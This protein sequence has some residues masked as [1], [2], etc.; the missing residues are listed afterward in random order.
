MS[1]ATAL[2]AIALLSPALAAPLAAAGNQEFYLISYALSGRELS[3]RLGTF[4]TAF[5]VIGSVTSDGELIAPQQ[6]RD[7]WSQG[8]ELDLTFDLA[9]DA[10]TATLV[11]DSGRAANA[12]EESF[13]LHLADA[14]SAP[15]VL[16]LDAWS[17]GATNA[18]VLLQDAR[19]DPTG[20]L[21]VSIEDAGGATIGTPPELAL[22]GLAGR[23]SQW[24]TFGL[25]LPASSARVVVSGDNWSET[26]PLHLRLPS[27]GIGNVTRGAG[28][29]LA[30]EID[31]PSG[32]PAAN[33]TV[34]VE[35]TSGVTIAS[36]LAR[37]FDLAAASA[38]SAD[39]QLTRDVNDARIVLAT[40]QGSQAET[41]HFS[42]SNVTGG[43]LVTL[44]TSLPTHDAKP[45]D[46]VDYAITI[47]NNEAED[48]LVSLA[49]TGLPSDYTRGF[50]VSGSSV[51][52]VLV[53]SEGS[54]DATLEIV[55]PSDAASTN[56]SLPLNVTAS[57]NGAPQ[58]VLALGLGVQG[59]GALDLTGDNWLATAPPGGSASTTIT[60]TNS[61]T[62]TETDVQLSATP[63]TGWQVAF[64]PDRIA[65]LEPGA[66]RDVAVTVTPPADTG[67]G[68]Y[69]VDITAA[70]GDASTRPRTLSVDVSTPSGSNLP[71]ILGG[72]ALAG[73]AIFVIVRVKRR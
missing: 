65:S 43:G 31:D 50:Y 42:S 51:P 15:H 11:I 33:V 59:A 10:T 46:T 37:T 36:P 55:V 58:G 62:A 67:T 16:V 12:H 29:S 2:V 4:S 1:R 6:T 24:A 22:S 34:S 28:L 68:R 69:L 18:S 44:K 32:L 57:V 71:W 7:V 13:P 5:S 47:E 53:P 25:S 23:A 26:T 60:V 40:P 52:S 45:G 66:T 41:V 35:D 73:L 20:P 17:D 61:G 3:V 38:A 49:L 39:F 9:T 19:P 64:T 30:V 70:S 8:D 63:P 48:E 54:V 21:V 27:V 14:S 72:L 56:G